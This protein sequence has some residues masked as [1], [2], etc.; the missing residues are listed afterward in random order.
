MTRPMNTHSSSCD[1][2]FTTEVCRQLILHVGLNLSQDFC[3]RRIEPLSRWSVAACAA[4]RQLIAGHWSVAGR[5]TEFARGQ[6]CSPMHT[7]STGRRI[8]I[9]KSY[10]TLLANSVLAMVATYRHVTWKPPG[11]PT[12]M[13][14]GETKTWIRAVVASRMRR[15]IVSGTFSGFCA[16][17]SVDFNRLDFLRASFYGKNC[18]LWRRTKVTRPILSQWLS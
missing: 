15:R 3:R 9:S 10:S 6:Q 18:V 1:S 8:L 12:S 4:E 14:D 13:P 11:P 7:V 5:R 16:D 17:F 2:V